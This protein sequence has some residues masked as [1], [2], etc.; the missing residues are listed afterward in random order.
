M[1]NIFSQLTAESSSVH[2]FY[3][4]T[5]RQTYLDNLVS[6]ILSGIEQG[7]HILII[8]SERL[9]PLLYKEIN[10]VLTKEQ[11]SQIHTI[12]N[13]DYY[14][15]SG[16]FQP[17]VIFNH[18]SQTLV[19]FYEKQLSFRIWA[20][21]EWAEQEG[22]LTI[23]EEFENEADEIVSEQG[24]FLVCAYDA[25]RVPESLKTSLMKCHEY[26]MLENEIIPSELYR[27]EKIG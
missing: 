13:F 2:I 14:C 24:L 5:E 4:I 8:E 17:E 25:E 26:I 9:L 7:E 19:P 15:S 20:H 23:L 22:I 1:K 27:N 21:V 11:L 12:N 16:S 18:L 3:N 6:Y 10:A